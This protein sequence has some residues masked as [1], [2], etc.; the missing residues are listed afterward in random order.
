[1]HETTTNLRRRHRRV[2][3]EHGNRIENFLHIVRQLREESCDLFGAEK[4]VNDPFAD[5]ELGIAVKMNETTA[6]QVQRA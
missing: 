5:V 4:F 1:M 2:H 6:V 3:A